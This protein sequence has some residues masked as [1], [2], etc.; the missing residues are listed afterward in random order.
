MLGVFLKNLHTILNAP[1]LSILEFKPLTL[2]HMCLCKSSCLPICFDSLKL[3]SNLSLSFWHISPPSFG[4]LYLLLVKIVFTAHFM[5]FL[6]LSNLYLLPLI[7]FHS[8]SS[9]VLE[10]CIYWPLQLYIYLPEIR[11]FLDRHPHGDL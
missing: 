3:E 1:Y 6:C 5:A 7:L 2:F 10:F 8:K 4:Y 11:P 9:T